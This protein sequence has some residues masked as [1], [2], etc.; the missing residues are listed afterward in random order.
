MALRLHAG[1]RIDP[2][3][4]GRRIFLRRPEAA[5]WAA[6]A[7]LRSRS[8]NF[9]TPWEP[10]WPPDSLSR[11]SFR[12]RLRRQARE[13]AEDLDHAFFI[14]L[15]DTPILI[16]GI[17]VGDV[18]RGAADSATIGYWIGEP[19]ARQGYMTEALTAIMNYAFQK[20]GLHRLQAACMLE[21]VASQRLLER[22]NFQQE[23]IARRALRIDGF[24]RDHS[25]FAALAEDRLE[26]TTRS[27]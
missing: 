15:R 5:D 27:G 19:F 1:S 11:L 17:T 7:E 16:G 13:E 4:L 25:L 12:R 24:W 14:F 8:R 22:C 18:Q 20:L 21:N 26:R 3:L 6:W 2:M 10:S 9:L 23:G